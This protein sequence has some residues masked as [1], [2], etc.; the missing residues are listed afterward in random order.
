MSSRLELKILLLIIVVL[1]AGFGTYVIVSISSQSEMLIEQNRE[2]SMVLGQTIMVGIRNVMLSGK[3]SFASTFINDARDSLASG[4]LHVY[5]RDGNEVYKEEGKGVIRNSGDPG[6]A[7]VLATRQEVETT[8]GENG[9]VFTRLAPLLNDKECQQCHGT[10]HVMRGITWVSLKPELVS[11]CAA[12]S[13]NSL[14]GADTGIATI[15]CSTLAAGFRNIMVSGEGPLMDTL[16]DHTSMLPFIERIQ[17]YDSFGDLHFGAEKEVQPTSTVLRA[18]RSEKPFDVENLSRGTITRFVPLRNEERCQVCHSA[19]NP[20]RGVMVVTL[21]V[22]GLR[23]DPDSLK[24]EFTMMLQ[25]AVGAGFKSIMLVGKGSFVRS[26]IN[27][28]RSIPAIRD[29]RVFDR[30]GNERFVD[31]PAEETGRRYAREVLAKKEPIETQQVINGEEY[32]V[33]YTPLINDKRCQ[34]CHGTDHSVRGVV[35]V[36]ASMTEINAAVSKNRIYSLLAGAVTIALVWFVLRLFMKKVVVHPIGNIGEV[37]QRVGRGDFTAVATVRSRD[38]IGELAQRINEMVAGLRERFHL[39]KFVS[40]QT[41]NAVHEAD[42]RGVKLGGERKIATVFFT[43]VRGFTSFSEKVE[44]E[45]VVAMLNSLLS[46]QT[47]L[48]KKY[49][50]DI[51]KFVGDELV[52]V[53]TGDDMVLRAVRCAIEIQQTMK[54]VASTAGEDVGIGIGINTGEMV[55]GAMGSEDRMDFTVIGDSVNLGARLCGA[56]ERGQI[57]IS[58]GSAAYLRA[59]DVVPL[60]KLDPVRVK[61]KERPVEIYEVRL[62]G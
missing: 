19:K 15:V 43:D 24:R 29:L 61:G 22:N 35:A 57:L 36:A 8:S 62:D 2:K 18:I 53:F 42:Q 10:T 59:S 23:Q 55:M 47:A 37:A 27:E 54:D 12:A 7:R 50:G 33:R 1:I 46:R 31:L 41:V 58:E 38:E 30:E 13:G 28:V 9:G 52:A 32:F 40:E 49:G 4:M 34:G 48:V 39:Q 5:N 16:I 60:K 26:F 21:R 45:R 14:R 25:E 44:P 17:V 51:D 6:V 3:G 56:A 11:D 20:W